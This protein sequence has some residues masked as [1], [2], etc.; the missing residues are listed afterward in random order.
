MSLFLGFVGVTNIVVLLP[1]F[2]ILHW[3][4][5]EKFKW[6][7]GKTVGYLTLNAVIGTCVSDFCWAK[8][9][10]FLGPLIT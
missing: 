6:P 10:A 2:P 4:G 9:V 5:V 7:D 1:L 8:S 3:T